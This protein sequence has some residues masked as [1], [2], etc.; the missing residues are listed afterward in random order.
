MDFMGGGLP[1]PPGHPGGPQGHLYTTL[2]GRGSTRPPFPRSPADLEQI[3]DWH[4][5]GAS[6]G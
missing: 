5:E 2:D 3:I 1:L 4:P 6:R